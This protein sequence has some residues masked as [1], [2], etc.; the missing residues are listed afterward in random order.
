M[1]LFYLSF[2]VQPL[3]ILYH[4]GQFWFCDVVGLLKPRLGI[5]YQTWQDTY[6]T[7]KFLFFF[8]VI[9]LF[10]MTS[11]MEQ[12]FVLVFVIYISV[13]FCIQSSVNISCTDFIDSFIMLAI[14]N[15]FCVSVFK[16]WQFSFST[17]II[18]MFKYMLKRLMT[19]EE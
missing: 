4:F 2:L 7:L 16:Y 6:Y 19:F 14:R 10:F 3:F 1:I 11:L 5:I 13:S 8:I 15:C 9:S 17:F 12:I 18:K